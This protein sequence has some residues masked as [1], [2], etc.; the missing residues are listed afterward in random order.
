MSNLKLIAGYRKMLNKTQ[1]DMGKKL[2]IAESTYRNKENGKAN[3][4]SIE[5]QILYDYF[6][7][8]LPFDIDA[9]YFFT[10]KPTYTD[11]K[12]GG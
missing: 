2:N 6:C 5:L 3:F 4:N 9:T 12:R 11:V 1:K 10:N 8:K 7:E